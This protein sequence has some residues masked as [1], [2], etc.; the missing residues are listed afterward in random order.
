MGWCEGEGGYCDGIVA[1]Q[2]KCNVMLLGW[3][4]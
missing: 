4:L 3:C 1:E 2:I